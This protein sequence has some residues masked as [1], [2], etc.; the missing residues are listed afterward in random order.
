MQHA[1]R[2]SNGK[3]FQYKRS[4]RRS[5]NWQGNVTKLVAELEVPRNTD[6]LKKCRLQHV[7]LKCAGMTYTTTVD[8]G[9]E[10]TI[11]RESLIPGGAM[12]PS[13]FN[14]LTAFGKAVKTRAVSLP[15]KF[16]AVHFG[17]QQPP[18]YSYF[19]QSLTV[20]PRDEAARFRGLGAVDGM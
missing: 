12:Q 14:R 3:G 1:H 4:P 16:E 10:I 19:V 5:S 18:R 15:R 7:K 20:L 8:R 13:G 9:S 2:G 11:Y 6:E 17:G